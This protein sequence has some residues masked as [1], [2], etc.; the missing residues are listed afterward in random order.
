MDISY[1][2]FYP[3]I[4]ICYCCLLFNITH[5][6]LALA[7]SSKNQIDIQYNINEELQPFKTKINSIIKKLQNTVETYSE[8]QKIAFLSSEGKKILINFLN[9]QGYLEVEV[10]AIFNKE[11]KTL[12]FELVSH[13]KYTISSIKIRDISKK[14]GN[15]ILPKIEE[16]SLKIGDDAKITNILNAKNEI[17]EFIDKNDCYLYIDINYQSILNHITKKLEIEFLVIAEHRAYIR[18]IIWEGAKQTSIKF[19]NKLINLEKNACFNRSLI[20]N[21]TNT[22]METGLFKIVVPSI[23]EVIDVTHDNKIDIKFYLVENLY[24]SFKLRLIYNTQL[25]MEG[26]IGWTHKNFL[27]NAETFDSSF[28][29]NKGQKSFYIGF[30]APYLSHNKNTSLKSELELKNLSNKKFSSKDVILSTGIRYELRDIYSL[31]LG[32]K[33]LKMHT[34]LIPK[35]PENKYIYDYISLPTKFII[36]SRDDKYI[37]HNGSMLSISLEPFIKI[38][39]KHQNFCKTSLTFGHYLNIDKNSK[40]NIAFIGNFRYIFTESINKV[41]F[42]ER[43]FFGDIKSARGYKNELFID[44]PTKSDNKNI[45]NKWI[46]SGIGEIKRKIS[47]NTELLAFY[48]I[49]FIDKK[50]EFIF[51]RKMYQ[52]LGIGIVYHLPWAPIRVDIAFPL[53]RRVNIDKGLSLYFNIGQAL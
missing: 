29:I 18:S 14:P 40:L 43:L 39:T 15:F 44:N 41:P 53:N 31:L 37:T 12:I 25:G 47:Q 8:D 2:R 50:R 19:L 28:K 11:K 51:N 10:S 22:L 42:S 4:L 24:K 3:I 34:Q 30:T 36:D 45:G 32:I 16:L 5:N 1:I 6:N 17:L 7:K 23:P 49:S 48:E 27:R 52:S 38:N 9:S 33:Y 13:S 46:L 20:K 21:I 35:I 26:G